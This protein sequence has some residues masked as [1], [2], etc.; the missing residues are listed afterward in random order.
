MFKSIINFLSSLFS[1]KEPTP[2]IVAYKVD[3]GYIKNS[4]GIWVDEVTKKFVKRVVAEMYENHDVVIIP[5]HGHYE[6]Y[7]DDKFICSGDTHSECE[8]EVKDYITT[9]A[10]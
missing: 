4:A 7:I 3:P 9:H 8:A 10:N 6:A 2:E 5:C 1:K